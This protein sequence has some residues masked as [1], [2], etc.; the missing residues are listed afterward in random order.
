MHKK[1]LMVI[2]LAVFLASGCVLIQDKP[3]DDD[4]SDVRI[5]GDVTVSTV[6]RKEF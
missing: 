2:W 4:L 1:Q 5:S 3:V 6:D